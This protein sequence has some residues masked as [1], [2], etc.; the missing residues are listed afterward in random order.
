MRKLLRHKK[1]VEMA[2]AKHHRDGEVEIDGNA[3]LSEGD[4]NGTYVQAWVWV[5][6]AGTEFDKDKE[7]IP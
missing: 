1:I 4:S 3:L 2:K 5:D 6:F 7:M